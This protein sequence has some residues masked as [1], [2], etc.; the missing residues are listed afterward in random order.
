MPWCDYQKVREIGSGSFGHAYLVTCKGARPTDKN[1]QLLVMKEIDLSKMDSRERKNAEVEVRVLSCLKHPY[2]VRYSE[3]FVYDQKLCI[4]MDYCE[5]GDLSQYVSARRRQRTTIPEPQVLRWLTQMSLALKHMHDKNVLHRDIKTQN[6]FLTKRQE[7]GSTSLSTV[8]IADF[9]I[10]KVLDSHTALA[11]TQVGT[12]YYLSPE[13]CQKQSYSSPSDIWALGCVLYELCALH[14]PF[15]A[16]D[17]QKLMDKIVRTP[18][19]RI[20]PT[21]TRDLGDLVNEMLSRN[22]S[23]RPT[24]EKVLQRPMLQGEIKKMIAENHKPGKDGSENEERGRGRERDNA[25]AHSQPPSQPPN[26]ARGNYQQPRTP[27]QER[28]HSRERAPSSKPGSR[29]PSPHKE[30]AKQIIAPSRAPSPGRA[31]LARPELPPHP[32]MANQENIRRY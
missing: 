17:L 31:H 21:Y 5:G 29:A 4:V 18:A 8:K 15:E 12:P 20:P 3:S 24:A 27:L 1:G 16:N 28:N 30:V 6:V 32:Q 25:R 26:S 22:A 2:I 7:S 19:S 13:I 14:V 11:R 23:Q 9:G 10:S